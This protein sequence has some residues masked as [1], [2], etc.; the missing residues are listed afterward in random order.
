MECELA[1]EHEAGALR[2]A[3]FLIKY[4]GK[5]MGVAVDEPMDT[6]TT[7]DKLALVTVGSVVT[8]T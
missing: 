6:I 1:P 3:A 8:P 2:V 5:D 4:Y 7:K